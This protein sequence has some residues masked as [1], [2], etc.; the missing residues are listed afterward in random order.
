MG[1]DFMELWRWKTVL[2]DLSG[3]DPRCAYAGSNQFERLSV[4]DRLWIVTIPRSFGD[5]GHELRLV[6]R[7]RVGR[8]TRDADEV[9]RI[10]GGSEPWPAEW[11]VIAQ[12]GTAEPLHLISLNGIAG[13]LRFQSPNDRLT[14]TEGGVDARQL[15]AMRELT[16]ESVAMLEALWSS[17]Q[18]EEGKG[19]PD[20]TE[21]DL[22]LRPTVFPEGRRILRQHLSRERNRTLVLAAKTD[23][24]GKHGRLYCEVCEFDFAQV[25]GE[26]GDDYIEA[27]HTVPLSQL[28]GVTSTR[29]EEL[30]MV[31]ANCHRMLHRGDPILSVSELRRLVGQRSIRPTGTKEGLQW[32]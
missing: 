7:L 28:G 4:G 1:R 3:P 15:Q 23:F 20:I 22:D 14:L 30:A 18:G 2:G 6:G 11:H 9:R 10:A 26:L 32:R 16:A 19:G 31:C 24:R 12:E 8:I 27:H 13:A 17:D 21:E 29:I 25:Y 5:T